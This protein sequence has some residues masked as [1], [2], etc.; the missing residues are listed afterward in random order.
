MQIFFSSAVSANVI[1]IFTPRYGIKFHNKSENNYII[2]SIVYIFTQTVVRECDI[3]H[4]PIFD[5]MIAIQRISEATNA[6]ILC[7]YI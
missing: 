4:S 7:L 5:M 3:I 6:L 2:A 1:L